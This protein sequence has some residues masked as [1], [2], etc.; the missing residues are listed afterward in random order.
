V[1]R[2]RRR[3]KKEE[4]RR[5]GRKRMGELR[6]ILSL[7]SRILRVEETGGRREGLAWKRRVMRREG[8]EKVRHLRR[9]NVG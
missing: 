8:G 2:K 6:T 9:R 4:R 1:K 3:R 5:E 7:L